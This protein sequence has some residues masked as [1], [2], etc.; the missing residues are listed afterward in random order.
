MFK[1]A[2]LGSI[3]PPFLVLTPACILTGIGTAALSGSTISALQGALVLLCGLLA[4]ISVNAINE[5]QDFSS[6]L[7]LQTERTA[8]S[9]GS[10]T[11]PAQ[12][13]LALSVRRIAYLSLLATVVTGLFI[14]RQQLLAAIPLGLVGIVLII[15]YTRHLNRSALLCLISPG[16]AFGPLFIIGTDLVLGGAYSLLAVIASLPVFF[17]VNNLLLL[18]Q[19]PDIKPDTQVGRRHF[20]IRFGVHASNYVFLLFSLLAYG[21]IPLAVINGY[22]PSLSL[23]ALLPAVFSLYAAY[24]A[25]RYAENI[26][27]KPVFLAANV[28]A[29]II[30]P[31]LLGISFL[32]A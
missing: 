24:G 10:G 22:F 23:I 7:D 2:A 28:A 25:F 9:G 21:I 32:S 3:R 4:H 8:F 11:L 1:L 31:A 16:L 13:E 18:N 29:S 6:G 19:Y 12:P 17:L 14:A 20:P 5:Y 27:R 15:T 30:T 26:G